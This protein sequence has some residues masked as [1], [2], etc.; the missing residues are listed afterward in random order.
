MFGSGL[1]LGLGYLTANLNGYVRRYGHSSAQPAP[2]PHIINAI[3]IIL[4]NTKIS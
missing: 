2:F 3:T 1:G 4:R